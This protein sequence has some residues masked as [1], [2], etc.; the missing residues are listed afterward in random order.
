M[1]LPW[2]RVCYFLFCCLFLPD[3]RKFMHVIYISDYMKFFTRRRCQQ[4]IMDRHAYFAVSHY[5]RKFHKTR[6]KTLELQFIRFRVSSF[7]SCSIISGQK[8]KNICRET[9]KGN[10][11]LESKGIKIIQRRAQLRVRGLLM[12]LTSILTQ[13]STSLS[14][15]NMCR[16]QPT[17]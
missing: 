9:R 16:P 11:S 8:V 5:K 12:I 3:K 7:L 4:C 14:H 13:A 17:F 6:L 2:E 10:L 1:W 15:R